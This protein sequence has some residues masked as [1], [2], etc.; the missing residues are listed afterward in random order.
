[1]LPDWHALRTRHIG[2]PGEDVSGHLVPVARCGT[3]GAWH[4]RYMPERY[5]MGHRPIGTS[6]SSVMA[7]GRSVALNFYG[8]V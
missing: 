5:E 8:S 1:M 4:Q 6:A 3:Y 2:P 7:D